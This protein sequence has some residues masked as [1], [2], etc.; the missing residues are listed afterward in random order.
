MI[1]SNKPF[2]LECITYRW[3]GRV[4][5]SEDN[6]VG[7]DRKGNLDVWKKEIQ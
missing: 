1:K 5:P 6:D 2:F 7:V 4:G 3:R